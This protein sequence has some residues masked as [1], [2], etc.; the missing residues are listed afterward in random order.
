MFSCPTNIA[1]DPVVAIT[2]HHGPFP[3]SFLPHLEAAT[4]QWVYGYFLGQNKLTKTVQHRSRPIVLGGH[5]IGALMP[6]ITWPPPWLVVVM[7]LASCKI[8]FAASTVKMDK[9]PTGCSAVYPFFPMMTC[10]DPVALPLAFPV[11]NFA[12]DSVKV[13]MTLGDVIMGVV[14]IAFSMA[15]DFVFYKLG[16]PEKFTMAWRQEGKDL[17][18]KTTFKKEFWGKCLGAFAGKTNDSGKRVLDRLELAKR[19][20]AAL[21]GYFINGSGKVGVGV[22]FG[23][24]E[25]E[26]K[27]KGNLGTWVDSGK[28][29][30]APTEGKGSAQALTAKT[31]ITQTDKGRSATIQNSGAG[32]PTSF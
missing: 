30:Y 16:K 11:A 15:L 24:A 4:Q 22:P 14:S 5:D 8:M 7:P 3:P 2:V 31:E 19:G 17:L 10:A 27:S 23:Q 6:H 9:E 21:G 29:D 20:V 18:A 1:I 12:I 26:V 32:E 28:S 13:G 25:V